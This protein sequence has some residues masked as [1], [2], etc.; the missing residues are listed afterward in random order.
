MRL[1]WLAVPC[2][3]LLLGACSDA[4]A[5]A[6]ESGLPRGL[7]RGIY[8]L[9]SVV[10]ETQTSA[11]VELFLKRV[12]TADALASYQGELTYDAAILTLDHTDL[13]PGLVGTTFESTPGHVRFAAASLEGVGDVPVL[14]LRFTRRGQITPATFQVKVEEVA[15]RDFTDL[16]SQIAGAGT[17]FQRAVR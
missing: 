10:A 16:S 5:P 8:P 4:T 6:V 3:A 15:G 1:A 7:S 2:A 9:V 17:F 14:T 12:Q 13:P 11:Q